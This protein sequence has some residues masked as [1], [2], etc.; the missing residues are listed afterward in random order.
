MNYYVRLDEEDKPIVLY[1]GT[2]DMEEQVWC[3]ERGWIPAEF[4]LDCLEG[5]G[6]IYFVEEEV[7]RRWFPPEAFA[8]DSHIIAAPQPT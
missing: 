3:P 6:N 1:R 4:L 5:W 2:P 8:S 7:A